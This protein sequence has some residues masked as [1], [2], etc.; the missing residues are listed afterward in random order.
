M[1]DD[2]PPPA[3]PSKTRAGADVASVHQIGLAQFSQRATWPPSTTVRQRSMADITFI[4]SAGQ[5]L[6]WYV[7]PGYKF[8]TLPWAPQLNLRYARFSGDPDPNDRLKQSYDPLF[9]TALPSLRENAR[10]RGS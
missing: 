5:G 2:T 3:L 8:S 7:E 1:A 4:R 6:A 10:G 9:V